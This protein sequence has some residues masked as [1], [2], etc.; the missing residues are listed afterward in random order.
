[1]EEI[2]Q[3]G[4]MEKDLGWGLC[5]RGNQEGLPEKTVFTSRS[6]GWEVPELCPHLVGRM[7][8]SGR[9]ELTPRICLVVV[10]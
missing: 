8:A 7:E 4:K 1:M 10:H 3:D 9:K 5:R 2:K 6:E